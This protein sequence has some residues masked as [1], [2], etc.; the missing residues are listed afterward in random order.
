MA[1]KGADIAAADDDHLRDA[2]RRRAPRQR[3]HVV[4]LR[5]VMD[6]HHAL[7]RRR[8]GRRACSIRRRRRRWHRGLL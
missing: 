5:H 2:E 4:P 3:P 1:A 6:H 8:H 7:N